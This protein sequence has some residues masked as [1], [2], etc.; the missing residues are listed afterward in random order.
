MKPQRTIKS[1]MENNIQEV[2]IVSPS[3]DPAVNVSGVSSVVS[4]I[5]SNNKKVRYI[6]FQQGKTDKERGGKFYRLKRVIDSFIEWTH[7]LKKNGNAIIHYNLS[8]DKKSILRDVPFLWYA[9]KKKKKIVAH[10]HG[11]KYLFKTERPWI[12]RLFLKKLFSINA[13]FVVLSDKE[14][15]M[16]ESELKDATVYVLPN[17]IDLSDAST[18]N[19]NNNEG[20]LNIL[21][22]GRVVK[23]KGIEDIILACKILKK[24]GINYMLHIAGKET[25]SGKYLPKIKSELDDSHYKYEGVVSG[26]SKSDLLK[27]CNV[28]LLPSYYEGLPMSLLESMSYG[29]VPIITDVGSVSKVVKDGYNGIF[30]NVN[31]SDSI[32]DA[33]T[34]LAKDKDL[35][36]S[37]SA[38]A[39][40]TIFDRF[41]PKQ[42]IDQL[43][44]IYS[45]TV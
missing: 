38:N 6:H 15:T 3:L 16:I 18:F 28:F 26:K 9:F 10:I 20:F 25:Q 34:R 7:I 22:L 27:Q 23:E 43:N 14:K 42:Y 4:F 11:G 41:N 30:V 5:V 32:V 2:I 24:Q 1:C 37:L 31:D 45:S 13:S 40:E 39:K 35:L 21:F 8:M 19:R 36:C 44:M 29:E 12:I 17:V 33:V